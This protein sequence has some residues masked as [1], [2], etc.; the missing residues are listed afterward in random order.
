MMDISKCKV[1]EQRL[2]MIDN[3]LNNSKDI[4][5]YY[6]VLPERKFIYLS[7]S[8][9]VVLGHSLDLNYQNPLYVFE[10]AHPDDVLK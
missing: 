8:V 6:Q 3:I 4:I 2:N 7:K 10:N 9:E 5:Y 1:N